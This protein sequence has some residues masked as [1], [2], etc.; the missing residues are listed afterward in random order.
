M[1]RPNMNWTNAEVANAIKVLTYFDKM[2]Q[3]MRA[4]CSPLGI[5]YAEGW[6][7]HILG[8]AQQP[9]GY[10]LQRIDLCNHRDLLKGF[11]LPID[12]ICN[13]DYYLDCYQEACREACQEIITEPPDRKCYI[14][15]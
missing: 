12:E 1:T 2:S 11:E 14:P 10:Y 4:H 13:E 8:D 9:N 3:Q 6:E 7:F 15:F 5:R